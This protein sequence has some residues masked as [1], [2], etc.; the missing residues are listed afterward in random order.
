MLADIRLHGPEGMIHG[1]TERRLAPKHPILALQLG[2][3]G[4]RHLPGADPNGISAAAGGLLQAL[5]REV[6]ALHAADQ[7]QTSPL[8]SAAPPRLRCVCGLAEGADSILAEAALEAGWELVAVLPFAPDDFAAD[9]AGAAL[10]RYRVLLAR[11]TEVCA[12]DGDRDT[13]TA[14]LDVGEIVVEQS[15][16]LLAVWD[17]KPA[18]GPGG[19]ED[20]VRR[21]RERGLPVAVVPASGHAALS[22]LDG[23]DGDMAAVLKAALLPPAEDGAMARSYFADTSRNPAWARSALRSYERIVTAGIRSPSPPPMPQPAPN[24]AALAL[25]P[26]FLPADRLATEYAARYRAAGL[27][28]YGLILPATLASLLGWYGAGW[29][30][31]VGNLANFAI[32]LF[33][34]RFSAKGWWE[35]AH[36]RF[37]AYRALA[38]YLRN[39][40]T[41]AT[42]G[43]VP[44]PPGSAAHHE[45]STDWTAWYCRAAI[46]EQGL[47]TVR[48]DPATVDAARETV[49]A[50]ALGQV[51]FLLGRA[52]RFD[53]IARRLRQIGV[54]LFMCGM[55][56]SAVR[57]ALLLASAG[58]SALRGFNELALMLPAMAPIFLGLLSFNEYGKLATRY[59][60]VAAELR[61][62]LGLLDSAVPQRQAVL[63]VTRRIADTMLAEGAD[64]RQLIR[65]RTVSAY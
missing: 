30:Q 13:D 28:R 11:A 50:E 7:A 25:D 33:V 24:S 60:A 26:A 35:P 45:R 8:Y 44:R 38:E 19:T 2:V 15:D 53:D 37:I 55:A 14:Y 51:G 56:F 17:G 61:E 9:F 31:P 52:A 34:L 48:F 42:L 65:A 27:L 54:A 29:L 49:R 10:G 39:A 57:A 3:C 6:L 32:L 16:L 36:R 40:R 64:W 1:H 59:R 12:L 20:V 47:A 21:C 62:L 22:W 46:R 18:R 4:H 5:G 63:A 23:G 43:A 58:S 41:L